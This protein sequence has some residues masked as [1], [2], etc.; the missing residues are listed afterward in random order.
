MIVS[1]VVADRLDGAVDEDPRSSA[2]LCRA[3][4]C[5]H[6]LGVALL[7]EGGQALVRVLRA[8]QLLDEL[9]LERQPLVERDARRPRGRALDVRDRERRPRRELRDVGL[10]RVLAGEQPAD[11]AEAQRLVGRDLRGR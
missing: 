5:A 2:W 9:A 11:D 8:E 6:E 7:G 1:V 4:S 3:S 10:E